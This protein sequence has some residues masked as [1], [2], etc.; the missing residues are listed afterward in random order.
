M[1]WINEWE[2]NRNR[3]GGVNFRTAHSI[4]QGAG[5]NNFER[6]RFNLKSKQWGGGRV[7]FS[8]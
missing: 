7:K 2:R 6:V 5:V 1:R 8:A 3:T 4:V